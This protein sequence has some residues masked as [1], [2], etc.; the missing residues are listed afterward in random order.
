VSEIISV[1]EEVIRL[2][3]Q[4]KWTIDRIKPLYVTTERHLIGSQLLHTAWTVELRKVRLGWL[5]S[6]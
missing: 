2:F 6:T 4:P 5:E 1:G 3:L